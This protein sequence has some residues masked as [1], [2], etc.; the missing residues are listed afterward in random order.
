MITKIDDKFKLLF[1]RLALGYSMDALN[2]W[3]YIVFNDT[4]GQVV[5]SINIENH[6]CIYM[7]AYFIL[8]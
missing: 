8:P 6:G 4:K 3:I 1:V 7:C 5:N 2:A